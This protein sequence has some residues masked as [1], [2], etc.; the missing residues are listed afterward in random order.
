MPFLAL[1][2]EIENPLKFNTLLE[3]ISGLSNF[4]FTLAFFLLPIIIVIGG[5]F[6]ITAAGN[7]SKIEMG[8]KIITL[9]IIGF[10]ITLAAKGFIDLLKNL[11][12]K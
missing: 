12:L 3:V 6:F 2:V 7:P 8:K 5:I 10:V 1:A 4:F 11:F 9:G